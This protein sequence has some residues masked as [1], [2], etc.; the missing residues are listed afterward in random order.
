[1]EESKLWLD[2]DPSAVKDNIIPFDII[3][4][5]TIEQLH[6]SRVVEA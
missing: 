5:E 4:K 1:M 2:K 6:R 3:N